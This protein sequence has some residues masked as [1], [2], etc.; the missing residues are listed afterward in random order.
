MNTRNSRSRA[1][2]TLVA[3]VAL[4]AS[5]AGYGLAAQGGSGNGN[6]GSGGSSGGGGGRPVAAEESV[7]NNLAYPI[8]IAGEDGFD[9][10]TLRGEEGAPTFGGLPSDYLALPDGT[11]AYYQQNLYNTWQASNTINN[12]AVAPVVVDDINWG[13]NLESKDWAYRQIVRVETQLYQDLADWPADDP[14]GAPFAYEMVKTNDLTGKN[15]KVDGPTGYNGEISVSGNFVYGFVWNTR[16]DSF[17]PGVY[18]LTFSLDGLENACADFDEFTEI[19]VPVEEP[20]EGEEGEEGHVVIAAE[21][22]GEPAG[23]EAVVLPDENL[24]YIDVTLTE[25]KGGGKKN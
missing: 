6:G 4:A 20:E 13:D 5:S 1:F 11:R 8:L 17:G 10:P 9:G 23:N 19:L 12:C 16:N 14:D 18:R 3:A 21:P 15:E 25:R 22:G 7:G 24:T 2:V